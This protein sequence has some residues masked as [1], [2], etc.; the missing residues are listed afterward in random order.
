MCRIPSGVAHF[1]YTALTGTG[2]RVSGLL[3]GAS[4]QAALAELESRRL[5]P[6]SITAAPDT[7]SGE[8]SPPQRKIGE[9]YGQLADL[10][11]AG[12]P[13]LRALKL[14]SNRKAQPRL[15]VLFARLSEAVSKGQD[16]GAAMSESP[17]A[18]PPVHVAMVRAGERGGFLESVFA[19]LGQLVIAQ[20]DL[21]AKV[22]GNLIYPIV[23]VTMGSVILTVIFGFFVP[24]FRTTFDQIEGG[25][26][27]ITTLLFVASDAITKYGFVTAILLFLAGV[28]LW[29]AVKAPRVQGWIAERLDRAPV[30]GP[31]RRALATARLCQLLGA[32]LSHGV[33][34]LTAMQIAKE[35]VGHSRLSRAVEE[36]A[37]AVRAG[38]PLAP[39]LAKSGVIDDDVAE[40]ISV[41]ESAN[42]LDAVLQK[43]ASTLEARVDRMLGVAVRLIEPLLLVILAMVVMAVAAGLLLPLTKL[44]SSLG[45]N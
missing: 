22:V 8:K 1:R 45:G 5:T 16:L 39:P 25:V 9:A 2:R 3:A 34:M 19:R 28:G 23:L 44:S 32:M 35:G 21:R 14:L 20:A 43:I 7:R 17:H 13:L 26:P 41:G 42:N 37:E 6:V 33:P 4:E 12:V 24:K 40:M 11:H 15:A 30:V 18:F 27:A 38:Q 31:L 29:R 36:A 10:L